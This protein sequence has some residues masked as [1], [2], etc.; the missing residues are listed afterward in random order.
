MAAFAR[1]MAVAAF[2][3]CLAGPAR[4]AADDGGVA[5]AVDAALAAEPGRPYDLVDAGV[6]GGTVTLRGIVN[7]LAAKLRAAEVCSAVR[8]A[9]AVKN[10]LVVRTAEQADMEIHEAVKLAFANDPLFRCRDVKVNVKGGIAALAGILPSY[11]EKV[12]AARMAARVRGLKDIVDDIAVA[13]TGSRPDREI[14]SDV[15]RRLQYDVL[16]RHADITPSVAGG[17]VVLAG[18]ADT[19]FERDRAC[20]LA[21]VDGVTEVDANAVTVAGPLPSARPAP[22]SLSGAA[23]AEAV[24]LSFR[25]HPRL[26]GSVPAVE[27]SNGTA[28][29]S[30]RVEN[31]A[32]RAA[33]GESAKSVM[34][35]TRVV[36]R[37]KVRP[38]NI[39]ENEA[40]AASVTYALTSDVTLYRYD[41]AVSAVNGA[42]YLSGTVDSAFDRMA[43]EGTAAGIAGVVSVRNGLEVPSHE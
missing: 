13:K 39:P 3:A 10:D 29:L 9:R 30:G 23:V 42:V 38:E 6:S 25:S 20:Y 1:F 8:G 36:N 33:A 14:E 7:D 2:A 34:G 19:L 26:F 15:V 31:L 4:A 16:L 11:P 17:K 24:R 12:M 21:W 27:M 40:L 37:L 41:I 28:T 5:A 32:A 22:P 35:V 43:A 18:A